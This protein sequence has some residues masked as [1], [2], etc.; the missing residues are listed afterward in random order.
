MTAAGAAEQPLRRVE[1]SAGN[2]LQTQALNVSRHAAALRPFRKDEFGDGAEA[3]TEAHINGVNRLFERLHPG[4]RRMTGTVQR[5][6][7]SAVTRPSTGALQNL[8]RT[9]ER[10]HTWVRAVEKIWDFYFE[11]FG[12][13][14]AQPYANWLLS[15]DRIALDAYQ[16]CYMGVG[17]AKSVPAPPPFS[18]MRTGFS[19]ATFRRGIPLTK[20]GKQIN[21]FPLI[22]LPYHRLVNPWTL[23]AVLHEVSHNLQSDL[24]LGHAVPR[25]IALR[26][27]R[28]GLRPETAAVW[29]RWNREL[30]ADLSALLLGG[31]EILG[32]L[33]DIVGRSPETS[34]AFNP[35]GVHPTPY[36]RGLLS[37]EL[38]R[39][40][41]FKKE[42]ARF[43]RFWHRM[44]PRPR[45]GTIPEHLLGTFADAGP[46]VVDTVCYRPFAELG[47]KKLSEVIPFGAKEQAMTEEAARRLGTGDDPGIIPA[48]FLIGA[49]RLALER[50]LAPADVVA[51]SFYKEL[52]RR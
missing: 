47:G 24:G 18:Y 26:L 51:A 41:G 6:A 36:L 42:A 33:L 43:R 21:P 38:L 17:T 20:L 34:L 30:Y 11:L 5:A 44:Y 25:A 46:L 32:S 35:A 31:P 49:S 9:K 22:Q 12:Q 45:A 50:R 13:R 29:A 7:R 15:C 28:H 40:M 4:L 3:P 39:R 2:W 27:L 14:Q 19:P 48:R 23:G 8:L 16:V 37:M 10:A 1:R 52:A